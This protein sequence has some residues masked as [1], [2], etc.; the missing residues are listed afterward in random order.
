MWV[1]NF[2]ID[3]IGSVLELGNNFFTV[4]ENV[5]FFVKFLP[6]LFV[7]LLDPS[8]VHFDSVLKLLNTGFNL[9]IDSFELVFDIA[10][11]G[12]EMSF[13]LGDFE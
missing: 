2:I 11:K 3:F 7:H 10:L 8:P 6:G 9:L 13:D 1:S 5:F 12:F 4:I